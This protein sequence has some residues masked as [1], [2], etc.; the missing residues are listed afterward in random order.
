MSF[1]KQIAFIAVLTLFSGCALSSPTLSSEANT[2]AFYESL[3]EGK[4]PNTALL[5]LF[6]TNMPKGGDLHHHYSGSIYAETYL[7]WV[8]AK[9]W[10]IDACTLRVAKVKTE[11]GCQ[12]LSIDELI[13]EQTLYRKLLTLWSDKDFSNHSHEQLPPDATFFNTF[14]YF[15]PISDQFMDEGLALIKER[16]KHE[17]VSYIESMLSRVGIK[18]TDIFSAEEIATLNKTLRHAT[19]NDALNT[20]FAIINEKAL[21]HPTFHAKTDYFITELARL[22]EGIDDESFMMRYQTYASRTAEPL[23]VYLDLLAAYVVAQHSPL[24]VG[25]NIVAPENNTVA[26]NDYSLHMKMFAFLNTRYPNTHR[27]LHAGELTLGMVEPKELL[28]HIREARMIAGAERIGH[29]VDI[30]YEKEVF[31]LLDDL[32]KHAA[33]EINLTSNEFILGVSKN[34]HPYSVYAS[35]GVPMVISTDDSGV[36]RNNLS[37]E[38]VLLASRYHPSYATI[39]RYVYNSIEYSFLKPEEKEKLKKHLDARFERFE[40]EIATLKAHSNKH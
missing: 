19:T 20:L 11:E 34:A 4:E 17:N 38:Y 30:M 24:V 13:K 2:E 3:F 10:Y 35:L 12:K 9:G 7:E 18:S 21:N 40:N 29:G 28:F 37:A 27:S 5:T 26:I 15:S 1:I 31:S 8:K 39:K 32:K 6:F 33:I 14:G 36:S 16:A 23:Q 25:V 22:H